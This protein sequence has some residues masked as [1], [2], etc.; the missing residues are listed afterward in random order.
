[1]TARALAFALTLL[2]TACA[3]PQ[4]LVFSNGNYRL[5]HPLVDFYDSTFVWTA[6]GKGPARVI[7][8]HELAARLRGYDV[9]IYGEFHGHAGV[10]LGEM[11]VLRALYAGDPH[12]VLSLEQF[13]RDTQDVLDAY[14][15]GRIGENALIDRGRAWENYAAS[16]RPLISF[17]YA[18]HLPVIAAEAPTWEIGCVGQWGL[19]ILDKFSTEERAWIARDVHVGAGAYRD[20]FQQF[21][22]GSSVHGG[23]GDTPEGRIKAERSF[24]AQAARDDTMAESILA[25]LRKYPAARVLHLTGSFHAATFL[26]TVERLRLRDPNLKIAVITPV[27]VAD[28]AQPE[29]SAQNSSEG[30]VLQLVYPTPES[31]VAD[32]DT[33]AWA[34]KMMTRR[35][36][37]QCKYSPD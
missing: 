25:A 24:A 5:A 8:V 13:E 36:A 21:L 29:F 27:E 34:Q 18:H 6:A 23:G 26:G 16:Y 33:S 4:S 15:A 12:L 35:K 20:K 11:R 32:E 9:V 31:F 19:P 22:G 1:V 14:L 3:T 30:T 7:D 2:L 17:A 28:A 37:E 10:H